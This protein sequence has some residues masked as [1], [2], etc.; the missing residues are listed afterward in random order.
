M[1]WKLVSVSERGK[2]FQMGPVYELVAMVGSRDMEGKV[3]R[4]EGK[5]YYLRIL[6]DIHPTSIVLIGRH[7]WSRQDRSSKS[8][9]AEEG[10]GTHLE[11]V[12]ERVGLDWYW[13]GLVLV[14]LDGEKVSKW[15]VYCEYVVKLL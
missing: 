9:H 7:H 8:Q 14:G 12:S 13:Y 1:G 5:G 3:V 15:L 11:Y 6:A 10:G 2:V 4:Y